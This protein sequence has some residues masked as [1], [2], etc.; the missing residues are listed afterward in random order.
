MVVA[1]GCTEPSAIALAAA[2]AR[3]YLKG[4][5]IDKIK[6]Y[7]SINMIKNAIY[8]KI[9]GT[10]SCGIK[11]AAAIGAL[12]GKSESG[13]EI[14]EDIDTVTLKNA[15]KMIEHGKITVEPSKTNERLYI[16]AII[17]SGKSV[18]KA[19]VKKTH[20]NISLIELNGKTIV[21]TV[22]K[23]N[24]KDTS[25]INMKSIW[26]F[27]N[28]VKPDKLEIIR[29]SIKLNKAIGQE[30][31]KNSYGLQ[32]GRTVS[33][34]LING[35]SLE[36]IANY[37][38]ALTSAGCDARMAGST[39]KVMSN[40]GSG[41]QGIVATLPV[42]AFWESLE[43]PEEKLLRALTLSHLIT[44]YI[45]LKFGRISSLCG[46]SIAA[47]GAS[48]GIT[49][50][51]G[52]EFTEVE[53]AIQNTA[54]NLTGI[55]CD[56]AKAGCAL[57]IYTCTSAAILSA[58]MAV[59]GISIQS[60][61]GIIEDNPEMTIDNICKLGNEGTFKADKIILSILLNKKNTI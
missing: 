30:G 28:N 48:C 56:G 18:S 14:F 20:T 49:Y 7:A 55:L 54:G 60:S 23:K 21:K 19:V 39:L 35:T 40:S 37:A 50:L 11:L 45:K 5:C 10:D 16:E 38:I 1:L 4:E 36:S 53:Y 31:L 26:N 57:K 52:G 2:V 43:L 17:E 12:K 9:A 46:A 34:K 15:R 44:I 3:K 27:I 13:L 32:V 58:L 42:L 29:Q 25:F 33:K 59:D 61:N 51:M 8:V 6:I 47:T 22:N 24:K 41:N